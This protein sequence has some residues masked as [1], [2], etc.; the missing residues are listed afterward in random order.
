VQDETA[1]PVVLRENKTPAAESPRPAPKLSL[2]TS[3]TS[4]P[5]PL[6]TKP[7]ISS[8]TVVRIPIN[9]EADP[10]T[11]RPDNEYLGIYQES[12][13]AFGTTRLV[14]VNGTKQLNLLRRKV[15]THVCRTERVLLKI[16][17]TDSW[18][19]QPVIR[20]CLRENQLARVVQ[21]RGTITV[22]VCVCFL[23]SRAAN[24]VQTGK[25]KQ[26]LED[27][28]RRAA[29]DCMLPKHHSDVETTPTK[30]IVYKAIVYTLP[31]P[32]ST[33]LVPDEKM[34]TTEVQLN[35]EPPVAPV[36]KPADVT[37]VAPEY[38]VNTGVMPAIPDTILLAP[39]IAPEPAIITT[40]AHSTTRSPSKY[41]AKPPTDWLDNI[42]VFNIPSDNSSDDEAALPVKLHFTRRT[43]QEKDTHS[44]ENQRRRDKKAAKLLIQTEREARDQAATGLPFSIGL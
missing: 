40:A 15:R 4:K 30:K 36:L 6:A 2:P 34:D 41:P 26:S 5:H 9:F 8:D 1:S 7:Q 25:P 21:A 27:A 10:V 20:K 43:Q 44:A 33:L 16:Y 38:N 37:P 29:A 28:Q 3:S 17:P 22:P 24:R 42:E 19:V 35:E 31:S 14:A 11:W 18:W 32:T 13:G 39:V 23:E 12:S